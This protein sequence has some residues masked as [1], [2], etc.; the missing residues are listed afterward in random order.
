MSARFSFKKAEAIAAVVD[1]KL[2]SIP[3]AHVDWSDPDWMEKMRRR[4]PLDEAGVRQEAE[5]LL[6]SLLDAYASGTDARRTRIR[7]LYRKYSSFRRTTAV[8][9]SAATPEGLRLRLLQLS[10]TRE[11]EDPRDLI[12]NLTSILDTAKAGGVAMSPILA[13]VAAI[14]ESPL[15]ELLE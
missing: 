13:E 8:P 3:E 7:E 10:M 9:K 14:T 2:R 11:F 15:R 1:E 12:L 5:S 6:L 4:R